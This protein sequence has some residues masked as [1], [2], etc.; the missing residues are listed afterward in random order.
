MIRLLLSLFAILC[1]STVYSQGIY[2]PDHITVIKI[3]FDAT[4]WNHKLD[5]LKS[6]GKK[7][8][9][10]ATVEIDGQVFEEVGVRYKGNSSYKNPRKHN[11]AKLPFNLK[12]D[13][14]NKKQTFPGG[15]ETLKLSNVFMDPSFMREYLSYE[16]ARKYMPAPLCNFAKVYV[17]DQYI[18]LF[19]STQTV[20]AKLLEDSF[21]TSDGTFFKCDPEWEDVQTTP[22]GCKEGEFSS[23]YYI[24]DNPKCYEGWYELESKN[25]KEGFA[26]LINL[27][28]IL[29]QSPDK[30]ESVLNVD[31]TLWMHAFNHVLV[32]LDSYTGRFSHNYYLFKTPDGLMTPLIWDMNISFGGFRLDGEKQGELTNEELQ[33]FSLFTHFKNKNLKRPLITNVLS[34]SF[35]RKVYIGHCR[36]ILLEN[37]ANGEYL[38]KAEAMQAFIREEVKADPNRLY[39]F[40]NFEKS[41][42][43]TTEIWNTEIIGLEE[44]MS[45][46][47]KSLLDHPI[48]KGKN[49]IMG[50]VRHEVANGNVTVKAQVKDAEKVW[51]MHRS[52]PKEPFK[53]VEMARTNDT[54]SLTIPK[55]I[56]GFQYYVI[57]EGDRLALCSP[58][59]ASYVFYEVN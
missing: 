53:Q 18:G 52:S 48:F 2:S 39:S 38:K 7:E 40:D 32:N 47:T 27:S 43:S 31:M 57:A 9:M 5:S 4:D 42:H 8:R 21:G 41:L 23:L 45:V 35:W 11:K 56:A 54:Y 51:L 17:N 12:A 10:S 14:G 30:I 37:F 19:N 33:Q 49:P 50:E 20:D 29:N 16:I 44:L 58:E 13:Y 34:N 22:S 55:P 36:T 46:R 15:Y 28:K 1:F 59:R 6:R 25:K 26:D 24:G 3:K